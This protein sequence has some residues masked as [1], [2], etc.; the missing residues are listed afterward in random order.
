MTRNSL[1]EKSITLLRSIR[2]DLVYMTNMLKGDDKEIAGKLLMFISAF[3]H[4]LIGVP[5]H[6]ECSEQDALNNFL[7]I[8]KMY[9]R[10]CTGDFSPEIKLIAEEKKFLMMDISAFIMT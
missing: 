7:D 4:K 10:I 2:Q 9:D 3:Q 1:D 8:A 5:T 6:F